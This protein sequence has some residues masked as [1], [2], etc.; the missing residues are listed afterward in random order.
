MIAPQSQNPQF[1]VMIS[2][3]AENILIQNLHVLEKK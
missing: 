3:T 2:N 1:I